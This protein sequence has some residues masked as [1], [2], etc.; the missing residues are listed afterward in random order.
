MDSW[1]NPQ[2]VTPRGDIIPTM[3]SRL[4]HAGIVF[5]LVVCFV[6]PLVELFD[7]W[8]HTIQ[9]GN[10]AEYTLVILA[11][12]IGAAYSFTRFIFKFCPFR[13]AGE[14]VSKA[15]VAKLLSFAVLGSFFVSPIPLSPP[16]L[17]L[18]I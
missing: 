17:A 7:H 5:I 10:D 8:D 13:S 4:L 6:C 1:F 2:S 11:L 12:C 18:R 16:A 3:R 14:V 15:C 9:T